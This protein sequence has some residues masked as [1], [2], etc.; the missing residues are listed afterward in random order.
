MTHDEVAGYTLLA[1]YGVIL[2]GAIKIFGL[3]RVLTF[4]FAIVFLAMGVVFGSFRAPTS[5]RY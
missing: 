5:R 4:I 3:R 1:G 2:L